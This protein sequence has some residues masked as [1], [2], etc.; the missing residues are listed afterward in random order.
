[1]EGL[2]ALG[3]WQREHGARQAFSRVNFD[4][5][6]HVVLLQASSDALAALDLD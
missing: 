5:E 2:P 4:H 6:A 3:H 1:L